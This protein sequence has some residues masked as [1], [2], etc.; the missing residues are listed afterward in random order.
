MKLGLFSQILSVIA[1][2]L[3]YG[4]TITQVS[5]AQS[6][7]FFCGMS[8]DVPVTLVRTSRGNIPMIRWVDTY[9]Q[10]PWTP[11][12]R[13]EEISFRFQR[14]Y[15]NGTLNFLRAGK[16]GS[17]NVLCVASQQDGPCLHN[18]ILVTLKPDA[19]PQD[20]LQRLLDYRSASGSGHIDLGG[21]G[22]TR[23]TVDSYVP[24]TGQSMPRSPIA[25]KAYPAY[26]NIKKFI[27][28]HR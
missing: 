7:K 4:A 3:S 24:K 8:E 13:C 28:Y 23:S 6:N 15:D 21:S 20:T 22:V 5:Y 1:L 26:F 19:N 27:A 9:F 10:P 16:L 12:Q 25:R 11:R 17:Q 18:G 14:F 2:T